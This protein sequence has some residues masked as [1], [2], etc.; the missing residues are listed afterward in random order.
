MSKDYLTS[1][2][3]HR[4]VALCVAVALGACSREPEPRS[5]TE[6]VEN[7]ILLEAAIVR[8]DRDRNASRYDPECINAREAVKRVAAKEEAERRVE[9][10]VQSAKKRE[11]L[12]R[13]QEAAA[14]ARRRAAE[15][16][17]L[18]QEEAYQS[19][20]GATASDTDGGETSDSG[21][22]PMAIIP[23]GG[24]DPLDP[25]SDAAG[26]STDDAADTTPAE[27]DLSGDLDAVREELKRRGE[28]G[29]IDQ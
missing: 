6:F 18:R 1:L 19:Q 5:I 29:E 8:C 2:A 4:C 12:R 28:D 7:P 17:R 23:E 13:T 21:N 16:E 9:L 3:R 26:Q 15:V 14:E 20:F 27:P 25:M 10:E 24:E 22:V 11:A